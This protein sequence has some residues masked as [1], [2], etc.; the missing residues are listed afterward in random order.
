MYRFFY[1]SG[2]D[3]TKLMAERL[4]DALF[5]RGQE[6]SIT[7]ITDELTIGSLWPNDTI[8]IGYPI[9][10]FSMPDMVMEFIKRLPRGKGK[11]AILFQTAAD[12][13]PVNNAGL[14]H[15]RKLMRMKGYKVIYE[16]GFLLGCNYFYPL[17]KPLI[18]KLY[19]KNLEKIDHMVDALM[20]GEERHA[21][22][23][24]FK[25][26]LAQMFHY[27]EENYGAKMMGKKMFASSQCTLCG[28]CV[29]L[30]P[31]DNITIHDG[32]IKF[33][34]KCMWC[35]RCFTIC[36]ADAVNQRYLPQIKIKGG[37]HVHDIISDEAIN[38]EIY[39]LTGGFEKRFQDYF[40]KLE[41]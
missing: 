41:V 10:A 36:P 23:N 9:H 1:F 4:S 26:E 7:E 24:W 27:G 18:K 21:N 33:G 25:S 6:A 22:V 32:T 19:N 15:G 20:A 11:E 12:P 2:T 39:E 8:V 16:R 40:D 35:M 3:N 30:C 38:H 31:K 17:S 37:Y 13:I 29:R 5:K 14:V 34:S 28:K